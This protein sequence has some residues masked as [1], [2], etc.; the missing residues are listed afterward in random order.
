MDKHI[1]KLDLKTQ[2]SIESKHGITKE[3]AKILA[4][5][6]KSLNWFKKVK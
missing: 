1:K 6:G 3:Q 2:D 5:K 4:Q